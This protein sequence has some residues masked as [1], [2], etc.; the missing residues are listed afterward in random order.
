MLFPSRRE[1]KITVHDFS[2][3]L[4]TFRGVPNIPI[5]FCENSQDCTVQQQHFINSIFLDWDVIFIFLLDFD[6]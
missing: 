5:T 1:C 4:I 3:R 2:R 6:K